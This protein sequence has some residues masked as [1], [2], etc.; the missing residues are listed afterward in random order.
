MISLLDANVWLALSFSDHVHHDTARRWFDEQANGSCAFCRVTQL[1]LLRHLTNSRI[2]GNFVLTQERAWATYDRLLGDPRV[3][4]HAEPANLDPI[5]RDLS[6]TQ[7]P[8]HYRWTD[9]Y[10]AAFASAIKAQ[11]ATFDQNIVFAGV[12]VRMLGR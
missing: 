2:M 1:A 4:F 11:F 3:V 12:D 7:F 10:L 9:G 8:S 6:S 5:F